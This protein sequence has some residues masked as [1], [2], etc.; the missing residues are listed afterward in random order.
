[1][2]I[3]VIKLYIHPNAYM[4]GYIWLYIPIYAPLWHPRGTRD[5]F[6]VHSQPESWCALHQ[7]DTAMVQNHPTS[8]QK[9]VKPTQLP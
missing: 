6:I 1:M 9:A 7:A 4:Y 2:Y 3:Y 8:Q 5:H